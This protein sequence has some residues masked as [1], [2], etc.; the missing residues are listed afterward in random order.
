MYARTCIYLIDNFFLYRKV[1]F[2]ADFLSASSPVLPM[3]YDEFVN[4]C[5]LGV[6]PSI[7]EVRTTYNSY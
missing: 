4:G 1:I 3:E 5:N 2:H 7:Y 6:F